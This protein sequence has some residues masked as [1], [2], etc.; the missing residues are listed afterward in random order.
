MI[1]VGI[2][3]QR[4]GKDVLGGAETLAK[5]VAEKLNES[6]FDVTVFTTTAKDYISWKNEYEIGES[7]LK[8]VLIKRYSVVQE[9]NIEAFN[10]LSDRFFNPDTKDRDENEWIREQGPYSPDFIKGLRENEKD[11]D[12][13]MFFTY[14]YYTTVE[15]LKAVTK[16]AIL[17]PTAHNELPI[18]M[19][20]MKDVFNRPDSIFFLTGAE[21]DFI[22]E[23]FNPPNKMEL[24]RTGVSLPEKIKKGLF[25][26]KFAQYFPYVLYAGRIEAGK[27]LE[28]VF[29][30]YR[31]I[32]KNRLV[33]LILIGKQLM[34]I[35]DIDGIKYLGYIS[36]EEK[37][38]AF[39]EAILSIQPSPYESLSFTTLESFSQRTP[40]LVNK[41]SEVL[42]EHIELSNGGLSYDNEEEFVDNFEIIF[43]NSKLKRE[44]GNNGYKYLIEN[45]T[46]DIV[47]E[48]I[49]SSLKELVR[50]GGREGIGND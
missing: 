12:V 3:V 40:V 38:D 28:T 5:N 15:G 31:E 48:R 17:F 18:H 13:F 33:D 20:L 10:K 14:L 23:K 24:I 36:E 26:N 6:G 25:R 30:A 1:R 22:K 32:R 8:G 2:I 21:K 39:N 29:N 45:F 37:L 16:P 9:R 7:I 44:M 47:I 27:G 41:K 34:D 42:F 46:W 43:K 11:I 35:P 19:E 49:K 50:Q 4:Y